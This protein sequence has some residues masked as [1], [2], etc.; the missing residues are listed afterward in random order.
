MKRKYHNLNLKKKASRKNKKDY[1][2][3]MT[4]YIISGNKYFDDYVLGTVLFTKTMTSYPMPYT[5][6][7]YIEAYIKEYGEESY[8]EIKNNPES[9]MKKYPHLI[10][11]IK[12][13]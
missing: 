6:K 11:P 9:T 12:N 3:M 1:R 4:P 5:E 7:G 10:T 8:L 13:E 2:K